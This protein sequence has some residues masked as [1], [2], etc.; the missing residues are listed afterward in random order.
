MAHTLTE[1]ATHTATVTVPDDGDD[2]DAASVEVGFQAV[3]NRT[4]LL[5]QQMTG[6]EM[7]PGP[8]NVT[9]SVTSAANVE[10]QGDMTSQGTI[11]AQTALETDGTLFVG[12]NADVT[13]DLNTN[14]EI[15]AIQQIST[16]ANLSCDG[17]LVVGGTTT[18]GDS[19]VDGVVVNGNVAFNASIVTA[20]VMLGA[21][22]VRFRAVTVPPDTPAQSFGPATTNFV[23]ITTFTG[24]STIT[25][26]DTGAGDGDWMV[27]RNVTNHLVTI[28]NPSA[29]PVAQ[30][31]SSAIAW[32]FLIRISGVWTQ[33]LFG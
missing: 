20:M 7:I 25:I 6:N 16:D 32:V 29:V 18:L 9:G 5:R 12:G 23:H 8:I 26:D 28:N 19:S 17:N 15:H 21:G 31:Q 2:L 13:G 14:G 1:S 11:Y 4:H 33:L 30:I 24:P 27:F 3:T 22:R 10:A